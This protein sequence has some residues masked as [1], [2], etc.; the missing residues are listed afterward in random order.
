MTHTGPLR[1]NREYVSM[2]RFRSTHSRAVRGLA[3]GRKNHVRRIR[4]PG[5]IDAALFRPAAIA[6]HPT[7]NNPMLVGHRNAHKCPVVAENLADAMLLDK[8]DYAFANKA[9]PDSRCMTFPLHDEAGNFRLTKKP[10]RD[11]PQGFRQAQGRC[12]IPPAATAS[13][14]PRSCRQCAFRS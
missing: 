12:R 8:L 9:S 10:C 3:L 1:T 5:L 11:Y 4:P 13:R 7:R 14:R 2:G 6:R